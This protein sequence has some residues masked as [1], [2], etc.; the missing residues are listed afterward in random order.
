M[1]SEFGAQDSFNVCGLMKG[2]L[3]QHEVS[4]PRKLTRM[5]T[6]G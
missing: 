5:R 6:R 2:G 3:N 1:Y 4:A